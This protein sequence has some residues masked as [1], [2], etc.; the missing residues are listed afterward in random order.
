MM[1]LGVALLAI[2]ALATADIPE[3]VKNTIDGL[4]K[5]ISKLHQANADIDSKLAAY[6]TK[7]EAASQLTA[8][9]TKSQAA[10]QL[11]AYQR[12]SETATAIRNYLESHHL[13]QAG[14]KWRSPSSG[15][16]D[17]IYYSPSFPRTPTLAV[18]LGG[19]RSNDMSDVG[20]SYIKAYPNEYISSKS[21]SSFTISWNSEQHEMSSIGITWIACM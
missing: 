10:S 4:E 19:F 9:Q 16:K 8:Y 18:S 12:K 5:E 14:I 20:D 3:E 6:Q 15:L 21:R 2:A 11:S 7:S 17:T 13:C 1:K